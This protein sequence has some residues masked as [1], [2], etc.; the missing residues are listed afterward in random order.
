MILAAVFFAL[1]AVSLQ[2]D[3]RDPRLLYGDDAKLYALPPNTGMS[4]GIVDPGDWRASS[5]RSGLD[6]SPSIWTFK[7]GSAA[8]WKPRID[9][10]GKVRISFLK[11]RLKEEKNDPNLRIEIAAGG[12]TQNVSVNCDEGFSGWVELGVYDFDGLGNETIRTIKTTPGCA[13]RCGPFLLEMLDPAFKGEAT[14]SARLLPAMLEIDM[15]QFEPK[16][17]FDDMKDRPEWN[18]LV[19]LVNRDILVGADLAAGKFHP[20]QPIS[21]TDFL[22]LM[23]AVLKPLDTALPVDTDVDRLQKSK[24]LTYTTACETFLKAITA[25]RKNIDWFTRRLPQNA[26][27]LDQITVAGLAPDTRPPNDSAILSRIDAF[28]M[29]KRFLQAFVMAGPPGDQEWTLAFEEEFDGTELDWNRWHSQNGPS[30]HILSSRWK[31]NVEVANGLCKLVARKESRGGQDW[32]AG[33]IWVKK[34]VFR[35]A[36]G[37][38]EA[39]YRYGAA[40][41]LNQSF[42]MDIHDDFEIDVNEGHWPNEINTNLHWREMIAGKRIRKTQHLAVLV[43]E[44]LSRDF[45]T[46]ACRWDEKEIIYYSDGREIARKP[47]RTAQK[48]VVPILS[49]A[50]IVWAGPVNDA[51][52]GKSMDV[53][54]VRVYAPKK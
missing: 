15:N 51:L 52:H 44:D 26:S 34:E 41:G 21:G 42:W 35:Q 5:I 8:V 38:W 3:Q 2:A 20:D 46:Y 53:D 25:T 45:H 13:S 17:I 54:W 32:T 49:L 40:T 12:K 28:V 47:A 11:M 9:V 29:A 24:H 6:A 31:E 36:Y 43:P 50:V 22:A 30:G 18:D 39:R 10:P 23:N 1:F 33:S 37:Y 19:F 16:T 48:P 7:V 14:S 27:S 4:G